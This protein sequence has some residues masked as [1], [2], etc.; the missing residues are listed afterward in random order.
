[1]LI[2]CGCL[3]PPPAVIGVHPRL[4]PGKQGP[5]LT[6]CAFGLSASVIYFG[7]QD[8]FSAG[9]HASDVF[10]KLF[11]ALNGNYLLSRE[12]E[13]FSPSPPKREAK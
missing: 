6:V 12:G 8:I 11:L 4:F 1:M 3:C 2:V 10:Y 9:F 7:L 5:F 13:V